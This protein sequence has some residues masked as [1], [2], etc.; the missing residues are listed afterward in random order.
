[1]GKKPQPTCMGMPVTLDHWVDPMS[2][3]TS[4]IVVG[5]VSGP[6]KQP[7]PPP[8]ASSQRGAVDLPAGAAIREDAWSAAG[9]CCC[10]GAA[11]RVLLLLL[12][13]RRRLLFLLFYVCSHFVLV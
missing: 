8:A 3:P 4:E 2:D 11:A 5:A 9:A 10:Q 13:L 12:L 1:M 7:E 6:G